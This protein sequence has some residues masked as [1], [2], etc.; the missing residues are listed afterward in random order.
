MGFNARVVLMEMPVGKYK[1]HGLDSIPL[2][3]LLWFLTNYKRM[4][5]EVYARVA[6]EASRLIQAADR[7]PTVYFAANPIKEQYTPL[8]VSREYRL[9]TKFSS[10]GK[11]KLT[12]AFF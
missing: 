5:A 1:G 3:Y 7:V 2:Y 11:R 8:R 12:A 9:L 6:P 4:N 10:Y